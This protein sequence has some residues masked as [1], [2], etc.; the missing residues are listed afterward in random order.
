MTLTSPDSPGAVPVTVW[1][2]A[3]VAPSDGL[4]PI[5]DPT[6]RLVRHTGPT[7]NVSR[8]FYRLVGER[9][10]WVDRAGWT[11]EQWLAWVDRPEHHLVTC[12]QG[13]DPVGYYE[14]EQQADGAVELAYFGLVPAHHGRGIGRW[15]LARAMA[16]AWALP[17]TTRLWLHTCSLDGPAA[18]AN[19]EAR[20][21]RLVDET[22]EYRLVPDPS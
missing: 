5:P 4:P 7:P 6:L 16:D 19:Y 1:S 3:T 11:D 17:G 2:L 18:R 22:V 10:L 14:L 8:Q 15:L 12:W 21:F 9:W 13:D 20:G